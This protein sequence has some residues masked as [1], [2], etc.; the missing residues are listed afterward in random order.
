ME[1]PVPVSFLNLYLKQRL[2]SRNLRKEDITMD[3]SDPA[4]SQTMKQNTT[5]PVSQQI[6]ENIQLSS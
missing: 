3:A 5:G 2:I 6:M 4:V 1:Q